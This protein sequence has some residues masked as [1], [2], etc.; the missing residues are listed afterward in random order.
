MTCLPAVVDAPVDLRS[1]AQ[2]A[3]EG[4]DAALIAT[5][6]PEFCSLSAD[7]FVRSMKRPIVLDPSGFLRAQL[8]ADRR[9]RYLSVGRAG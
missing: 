1:S 5:E 6:W 4:A 9:I 7:D 8:D 3:L 2:G